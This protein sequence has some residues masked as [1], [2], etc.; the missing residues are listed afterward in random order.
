MKARIQD[1]ARRAVRGDTLA[2]L[3]V[4]AFAS[5]VLLVTVLL[6]V[7]L[8]AA[9]GGL[10]GMMVAIPVAACAKILSKEILLPKLR[11][12]AAEH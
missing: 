10:L 11:E 6:V 12:L 9:L 7:M 5:L 2:H 4:L 8:G 1:V 3:V